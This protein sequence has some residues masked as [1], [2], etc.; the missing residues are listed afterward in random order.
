MSMDNQKFTVDTVV[1]AKLEKIEKGIVIICSIACVVHT[2]LINFSRK[3]SI[4]LMLLERK[5]EISSQMSMI[6]KTYSS[7]LF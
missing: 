2:T 5:K 4:A 1:A 6:V 3:T 7:S